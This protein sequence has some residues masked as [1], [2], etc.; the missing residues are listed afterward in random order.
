MIYGMRLA[1]FASVLSCV[2]GCGS[3][4]D[5]DKSG[6]DSGGSGSYTIVCDVSN[7][8]ALCE[9]F[10][11]KWEPVC[12]SP[13]NCLKGCEGAVPSCSEAEF[14]AICACSEDVASCDGANSWKACMQKIPCSGL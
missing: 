4:G 10:C 9:S 14:K 11:N 12:G 5:S 13:L 6:N 1:G 8:M 2:L 7:R 3:G